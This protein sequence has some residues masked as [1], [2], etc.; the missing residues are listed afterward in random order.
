MISYLL[1]SFSK[2]LVI[3][4]PSFYWFRYL[5]LSLELS[6]T[7]LC[8]GVS[9]NS[10]IIFSSVESESETRSV[11]SDFLRPHGLYNPWTP[12]DQDTGVGSLSLLH[13]IFPT[14]ELN[15]GLLHWR[16]ILYQLSHKGNPKQVLIV[17]FSLT[18]ILPFFVIV[19]LF[20]SS[21]FPN[22]N[23]ISSS[24]RPVFCFHNLPKSFSSW[25]YKELDMTQWLNW[26]ELW[27]FLDRRLCL[28]P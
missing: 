5:L 19:G 13:R 15:P 20:L 16:W 12:P 21:S 28:L 18:P 6:E 7:Y 11:M 14:Q 4:C 23:T 17:L 2:L 26:T 1:N 22:S 8:C 9:P 24:V 3:S 10:S 25:V 27:K